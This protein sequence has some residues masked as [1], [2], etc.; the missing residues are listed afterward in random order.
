MPQHKLYVPFSDVDILYLL[1]DVT[2]QSG[3]SNTA[4]HFLVCDSKELHSATDLPAFC[5]YRSDQHTCL[6]VVTGLGQP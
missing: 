1:C 4:L 6:H 5:L 3:R 2:A